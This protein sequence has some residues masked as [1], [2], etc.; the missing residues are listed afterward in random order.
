MKSIVKF[1]LFGDQNDYLYYGLKELKEIETL[2]EK[3]SLK[4]IIQPFADG[5]IS[6]E[7]LVG[8]LKIGLKKCYGEFNKDIGKVDEL[9]EEHL[10]EFAFTDFVRLVF[11]GIMASGIMGNPTIVANATQKQNK[12]K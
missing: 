9:F 3:G 8:V 5:D 1:G 12:A 11:E 10:G 6:I 4:A 7:F 2:T